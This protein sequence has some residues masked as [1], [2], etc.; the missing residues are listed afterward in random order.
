MKRLAGVSVL[1]ITTLFATRLLATPE[2]IR[3]VRGTLFYGFINDGDFNLDGTRGLAMEGTLS[4]Y[5]ASL[6]WKTL[7][8]RVT[9]GPGEVL[10]LR[11]WYGA[12][13]LTGS[14][15]FT[16]FGETYPLWGFKRSGEWSNFQ[17]DADLTLPDYTDTGVAE[18][19]VPFVFSG[20]CTF[21]TDSN[22]RRMICTSLPARASRQ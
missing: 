20:L 10:S 19:S 2:E 1:I 21:R 18:V 5:T 15:E 3:I 6:P 16:L 7:C 11:S 22:P 13:P 12:G 8:D 17:F 4:P 9:C 14:G